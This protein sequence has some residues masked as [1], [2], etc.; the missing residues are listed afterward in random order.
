MN[1]KKGLLG[2][3]IDRVAV[4]INLE[5]CFE[6][7]Q[8]LRGFIYQWNSTIGLLSTINKL[9]TSSNVLLLL[10]VQSPIERGLTIILFWKVQ[11]WKFLMRSGKRWK[12]QVQKVKSFPIFCFNDLDSLICTI[13]QSG[14]RTNE[15]NQQTEFMGGRNKWPD[16]FRVWP[17]TFYLWIGLIT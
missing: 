7:L 1:G 14:G 12:I 13:L 10:L 11:T 15:L 6:C 3:I 2:H 9:N 8:K 4:V 17:W 16:F 5:P